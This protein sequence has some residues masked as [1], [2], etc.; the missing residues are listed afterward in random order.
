[1]FLQVLLQLPIKA[2]S[3]K[4]ATRVRIKT[5]VLKGLYGQDLVS[6]HI[7]A[8]IQVILLY[9]MRIAF[10]VPKGSRELQLVQVTLFL[11]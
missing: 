7:L 6:L 10:N 3:E 1:M 9:S 5:L 2:N 8:S 11:P 4:V